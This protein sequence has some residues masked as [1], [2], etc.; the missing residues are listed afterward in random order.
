MGVEGAYIVHSDDT[1]MT[2]LCTQSAMRENAGKSWG[3]GFEDWG[4]GFED[5]GLG[6]GDWGLEVEF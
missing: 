6:F 2:C 4:L 5:W 1:V 3:L